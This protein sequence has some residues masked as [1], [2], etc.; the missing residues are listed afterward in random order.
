MKM[1]SMMSMTVLALI[2][3][4]AART[5][6]DG[7]AVFDG[8][9]RI[10]AGAVYDSGVKT[11][12]RMSPRPSYSSPFRIAPGKSVREAKAAAY[13]TPSEGGKVYR[14]GVFESSWRPEPP[15]EG[16]EAGQGTTRRYEFARGVYD[17]DSGTFTLG[18]AEWEAIENEYVTDASLVSAYDSDESAMPGINVELSRNLYHDEEYGWGVDLAFVFQYSRRSHAFRS[19]TSW[20]NGGSEKHSGTAFATYT[21]DDFLKGMLASDSPFGSMYWQNTGSGDFL[22][23]GYGES[24]DL[25]MFSP[26][27]NP[28]DID[29]SGWTENPD[30]ESDTSY[31]SLRMD[32]DYEDLELMLIARP[33]Y[34]VFDW[35]RVNAMLGLVVSRQ[36]MEMSFTMFRDGTT[37][38]RSN[39]DFSQW[40][41][42]GVAGLGLMLYWNDFTLG[43]DFMA[44]FLDRDMD[45]SDRYY[46]GSVSRGNWMFRLSAGYEF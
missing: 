19:G 37:D 21:V 28:E 7:Y 12:I 23:G 32:G 38:Y 25:E 41:V 34:D 11:D 24:D 15:Q 10:S 30:Y 18:R 46:K 36:E 6:A 9:W 42:Y 1:K 5:L 27:V 4:T 44:R 43:A 17:E 16:S 33:Y 31:G 22:G 8:G 40:D 45:I 20:V 3:A 13:G 29:D 39:R 2:A 26:E 35:L 14:N